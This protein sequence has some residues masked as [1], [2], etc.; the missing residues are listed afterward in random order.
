MPCTPA[1]CAPTYPIPL[2]PSP[3]PASAQYPGDVG[4]LAAWFLNY[5]R[6]QPGQAVA[7]PANEPHAY[8]SGEIVEIMATS[9]EG[10]KRPAPR[11]GGGCGGGSRS[12]WCGALGCCAAGGCCLA[13][14]LMVHRC[15][16]SA[17]SSLCP[18][19]PF[20]PAL[21]PADNVIRAGLTPKL[22]DVEALCSSLTYGQGLPE[23]LT[24]AKAAAS[25][26]L[27]VYRPPFRWAASRA[28]RVGRWMLAAAPEL[29]SAVALLVLACHASVRPPLILAA[30]TAAHPLPALQGV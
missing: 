10:S 17:S 12:M 13:G 3:A 26:H 15:L 25:P 7:L 11:Q 28:G 1:A 24:G 23:L 20:P 5:L 16:L 19:H 9:G 29:A 21:L 22:R 8:I 14:Q 30:L 4:V 2:L 27:A 18:H 6:L